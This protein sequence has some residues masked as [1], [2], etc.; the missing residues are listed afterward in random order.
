[1]SSALPTS[2][3]IL[4][5]FRHFTYITAHS[6][7]FPSL[8]LR[9]SSFSNLS[10]TSPTSQLILQPFRRFT[11]VTAHSPTFL[12]LHL[13]H[14]PFYNP[15]L[16]LPTPQLILQPFRCFAY[17]TAQSPTLLLL[18]LRHRIFTYV[19]RRAAHALRVNSKNFI[20]RPVGREFHDIGNNIFLAALHWNLF[21]LLH[22]HI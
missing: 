21:S 2:Q 19:T 15:S 8:H 13:L 4:Q 14:S 18:L 3:L 22:P 11:Y 20:F 6:P 5:P 10:V 16:A 1:M 9:H 12:S 17:V 7:T